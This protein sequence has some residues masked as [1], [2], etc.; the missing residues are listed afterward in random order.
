MKNIYNKTISVLALSA[1]FLFSASAQNSVPLKYCGTS[2]A[3]QDFFSKNPHLV[4]AIQQEKARLENYT[5]DYHKKQKPYKSGTIYVIP[6][7]F[8][9]LHDNG[10]ENIS[11]DQ[12]YDAVRI[13]NEDFRKKNA[14]SS[15]TIA[16]FKSIAWDAEIE[17]RLAQKD[18]YGN[19]TNG[20]DRI[21]TMETYLGEDG[22]KLNQWPRSKYLNIWTAKELISGAAGYAYLPSSTTYNAS[23]DG[24]MIL[25][26]YVGSIGSG[27]PGTDGALT[28]EVGHWLNL[29]HP[30]GGN[31]NPGVSCGSDAV[32]DTPETMGWTSC[33]LS[34]SVCNPP[35]IENVQNFMDYS[36]CE[37]M[38]TKDQTTRMRAA[39]TSATASRNNLWSAANLASTGTDVLPYMCS[40]DFNTPVTTVCAGKTLQF[41]DASYNEVPTS[42]AWTFTGATPST[43]TLENPSVFY[44]A[45]GTYSVSLTAG[46]GTNNFTKTKTSYIT[47]LPSPGKNAPFSEGFEITSF[48]NADWSIVSQDNTAYKWDLKT[49]V[50][51]SGTKCLKMNNYG[52]DTLQNDHLISS[53]IDLSNMTSG[54]I[55][56]RVAYCQ[57]SSTTND[58]LTLY[59]STN[60]GQSWSPRFAKTGSTLA[61]SAIQSTSFTP[62]SPSQWVEYTATLSGTNMTENFRMKFSFDADGGN[63]LYLDDINITGVFNPVPIQISPITNSLDVTSNPTLDWKA[64]GNVTS[65]EYQLDVASTFNTGSLIT[66]TKAFIT[67]SPGGTDTEF[68]ASNLTPG[69]KYYWRVRSITSGTPSAW[70]SIWNFTVS[71]TG[72]ATPLQISPPDNSTGLANNVIIDWNAV[73]NVD[74]YDYQLDT[75]ILFNSPVLVSG[76]KIYIS[77]SSGNTDTEY[78]TSNLVAG[79]KYFW[80]VRGN[81]SGLSSPWSS[82]WNFTVAASLAAPLQISPFNN[83]IY[84]PLNIKLDWNAVNNISSY[85]YQLDTSASFNSPILVNGNKTYI[86]GSSGNTDTEF[87][88]SNLLLDK[89]Y[90]W[91]V[92]SVLSGTPSNWSTVWNFTTGYVVGLVLTENQ[93]DWTIF[94]NPNNGIFSIYNL[95]SSGNLYQ[96]KIYT[97]IGEM[98]YQSEILSSVQPMHEI[99]L[100]ELG[101]GIYF[102]L[103]NST[104]STEVKKISI[105]K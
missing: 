22:S 8:H 90:Y 28:H 38:Y 21:W 79:Q 72:I 4:P 81:S 53:T 104:L 14:D 42:W 77:S 48:P 45:P 37:T 9:I 34:G 13:L 5:L 51:Y 66:G 52:N 76:N 6:V 46:I 78:Q 63:N 24:I 65:Y 82:S 43:S 67:L 33:N 12:V 19:C 39:L 103:L 97:I 96:V 32:N 27:N 41:F 49:G 26:N 84:Q 20:I 31:N 55:K 30:W 64:A 73:S 89:K 10:V 44:S 56:F 80:R 47:V 100:S 50:S 35:I 83:A 74:S 7:V 68:Q 86:S 102:V 3:E 58:K 92:R 95:S 62:S 54:T 11:D 40:A 71:S 87:Q 2:K 61:T 23:I 69:T 29:N 75:N 99:D 101:N 93:N 59:V 88:T 105:T 18:A 91:R 17:F 94:P 57:R 36:Y 15:Q 16:A 60:C 70:S 85:D 25:H 1:L 98:V